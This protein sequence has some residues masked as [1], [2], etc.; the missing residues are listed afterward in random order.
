MVINRTLFDMA[1]AKQGLTVAQLI[2]LSGCAS[3]TIQKAKKGEDLR[4]DVVG[5]L[6]RAL[7]ME[8]AELVAT[9]GA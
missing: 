3:G 5:R 8:P 2:A 4:P 7:D 9:E 6:A 1:L